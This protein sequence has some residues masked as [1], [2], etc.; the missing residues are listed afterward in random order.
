[1]QHAKVKHP[2]SED[3]YGITFAQ[4]ESLVKAGYRLVGEKVDI[5]PVCNGW[6]INDYRVYIK[7]INDT[8]DIYRKVVK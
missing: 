4:A 7:L 2:L 5:D 8:Y 6:S 1:M 3:F